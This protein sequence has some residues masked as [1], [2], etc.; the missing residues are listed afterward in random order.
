MSVTAPADRRFRRSQIHAT[1]RRR[2]LRTR[3]LWR[4][5]R[6]AAALAVLAGGGYWLAQA[7]AGVPWLRVQH[8]TVHGN[9]RVQAGE[10]LGLLDGLIGDNLIT[11]DLE[12]WQARLQAS[13]WIAGA[14]LRRRLPAT[15]DVE[16]REREPAGIARVGTVLR[17]VDANGQVVDDYG[18]RYADCDLPMIDGLVTDAAADAPSIDRARSQLV[19]R[20]LADLR[21]RPDLGKRISQIDVQ[22]AH[23]VHV[24]LDD[25]PAVI[26]LGDSQFIERLDSYIGLQAELRARVPEIDYVDLRFGER[27]FVGPSGPARPADA[28]TPAPGAPVQGPAPRPQR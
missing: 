16:I 23:D 19:F 15:V 7:A 8:I 9:Q 18:P 26:R 12:K 10:V 14:T 11:T 1:R 17:L 25:D 24:I 4:V 5:L 6:V 21:T 28:G 22:D 13:P 20:L 2:L 27:V 3:P